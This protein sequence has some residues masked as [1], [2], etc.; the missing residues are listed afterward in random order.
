MVHRVLTIHGK[1]RFRDLQFGSVR[2][3]L[4]NKIRTAGN[5]VVP[6]LLALEQLGFQV[7]V[8]ISPRGQTVTATRAGEEYTAEDPV[9]VLGLVKLIE[10]RTWQW[11]ATDPQ[12]EDMLQKYDLR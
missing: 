10:A 2:D 3:M 11:Q 12:I 5:T 6:A 7:S 4:N 8:C 9:A 1:G